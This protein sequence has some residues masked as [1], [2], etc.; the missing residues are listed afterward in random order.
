MLELSISVLII[1]L[2]L[3]ALYFLHTSFINFSEYKRVVRKPDDIVIIPLKTENVI[4]LSRENCPY[5]TKIKDK[6]K[7]YKDYIIINYNLNSGLEYGEDF[8]KLPQEERESIT[9]TLDKF[10]E[11]SKPFGMY[12]PTV[13]YGSELIIGLPTDNYINKIFKK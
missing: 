11:D 9:T 7:D 4:V 10:I 12:F 3:I 2:S 6:L 8:T 5:C 13:L 1:I